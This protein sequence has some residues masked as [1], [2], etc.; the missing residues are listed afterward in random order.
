MSKLN[1][2]KN[3]NAARSW[4]SHLLLYFYYIN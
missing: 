2:E 1:L 3:F 4:S